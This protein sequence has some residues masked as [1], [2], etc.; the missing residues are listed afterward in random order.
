MS[1]TAQPGTD[2][3]PRGPHRLSR[4]EVE[5]HQRERML[6]AML[7]AV[8]TKG[9]GSTT[10]HDITQGAHVSRDTFY[11]QFA[12]KEACFLAAYDNTTRELLEQMVI[13]G[14]SQPGYVEAMREGVRAYLK[15]WSARP[16]AARAC[17]VEVMA[18]G[19]EAHAHREGTFRS[20][21]R[22]YGAVAERAR[23]SSP[24]CRPSPTSF[25]AR[26]SSAP[27]NSR[28]STSARTASARCRSSRTTC[29]TCG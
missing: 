9:Y 29:S 10:I 27:W 7:A 24:T 5:N 3:L 18:A 26:S 17:T 1:T 2:R 4:A 11:E 28:L 25:P 8:A 13:A 20:F 19:P 14:T 21:E 6:S 15:F 22:L 12:N 23:R 16:N